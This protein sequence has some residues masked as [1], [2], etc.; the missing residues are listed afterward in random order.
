MCIIGRADGD[1]LHVV[2]A[3]HRVQI[4]VERHAERRRGSFPPLLIVVPGAGHLH[5]A[6]LLEARGPAALMRMRE[7]EQCNTDWAHGCGAHGVHPSGRS[8]HAGRAKHTVPLASCSRRRYRTLRWRRQVA[9]GRG[10]A[11]SLR[12]P[13]Q[14]TAPTRDMPTGLVVAAAVGATLVVALVPRGAGSMDSHLHG[15]MHRLMADS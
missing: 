4:G 9:R 6:R 8:R 12:L 1:R 15:A 10:P 2:A 14:P 13:P 11:S 3:E 7:A 5:V